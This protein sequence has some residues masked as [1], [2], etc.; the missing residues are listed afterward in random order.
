MNDRLLFILAGAA[1]LILVVL[2]MLPS[3]S[4]LTPGLQLGPSAPP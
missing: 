2:L 4:P 1:A 3:K